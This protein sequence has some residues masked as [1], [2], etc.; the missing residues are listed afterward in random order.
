MP[1]LTAAET[2]SVA[3]P[4]VVYAARHPGGTSILLMAVAPF[5]SASPDLLYWLTFMRCREYRR[6]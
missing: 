5:D 6:P 2:G 1:V 3:P 4:A